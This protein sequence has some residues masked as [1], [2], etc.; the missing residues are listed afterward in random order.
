MLNSRMCST[1]AAL[2]LIS[3]ALVLSA[4]SRAAD[5]A[6]VRKHMLAL[7]D[8][9]KDVRKA[10][11]EALTKSG[12]M[13]LISF[14]KDFADSKIFLYKDQ[15]V[16]CS[17]PDNVCPLLDPLTRSPLLGDPKST[18]EVKAEWKG[19]SPNGRGETN[20]FESARS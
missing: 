14:F 2:S 8:E 12:D 15:L 19:L 6:E 4:A 1:L 20:R 5:E 10:E 18:P 17:D 11:L 7:R 13:R 16:Y 9:D 3:A